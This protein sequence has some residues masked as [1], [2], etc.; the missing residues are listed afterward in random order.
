MRRNALDRFLR[1]NHRIISFCFTPKLSG[2]VVVITE[3][4]DFNACTSGRSLVSVFLLDR[5]LVAYA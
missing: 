5:P 3:E 4:I 1:Q 2:L